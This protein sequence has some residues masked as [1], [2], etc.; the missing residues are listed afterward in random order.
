MG[1]R[2]AEDTEKGQGERLTY[3]GLEGW[4]VRGL[5]IQPWYGVMAPLENLIEVMELSSEKHAHVQSIH[6]ACPTP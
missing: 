4:K 1:L 6:G 2:G 5:M 3:S